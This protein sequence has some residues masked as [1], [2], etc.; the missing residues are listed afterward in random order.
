MNNEE[1]I[2]ILPI[3]IKIATIEVML[4]SLRN[5]IEDIC[6]A[7]AFK[8]EITSYEKWLEECENSAKK[9]LINRKEKELEENDR[10]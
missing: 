3:E 9:L 2:D 1:E 10:S 4:Y 6:K 7:L 5:S 8:S